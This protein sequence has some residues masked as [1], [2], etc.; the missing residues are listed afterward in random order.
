[1]RKIL[2]QLVALPAL[3]SISCG[4]T[5]D[6]PFDLSMSAPDLRTLTPDLRTTPAST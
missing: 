3:V 1:M 4:G 5:S 6:S 2:F